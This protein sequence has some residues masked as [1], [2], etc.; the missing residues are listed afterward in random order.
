VAG[1]GD[2]EG[3]ADHAFHEAAAFE[4]EAVIAE[5]FAVV[6]GEDDDGVFAL[7]GVVEEVEEVTEFFV[8]ELDGGVVG[9]LDFLIL[10][11]VGML[12]FGLE[13]DAGV[14]EFLLVLEVAIL[15]VR[16]GEGVGVVAAVVVP[17]SV[18][19]WVGI[20]RIYAEEPGLVGVAVSTDE[21]F[22]FEGAPVGLVEVGWDV[23][24]AF[25]GFVESAEALD[26]GSVAVGVGA[27]AFHYFGRFAALPAHPIGVVVA[28][29]KGTFVGMAV[30]EVGVA[31]VDARF[32]AAAGA[33]EV[34]FAD[35]AAFVTGVGETAGKESLGEFGGIEVAAVAVDVDGARVL[36]GEEAGA[37][38]GADGG[39]AEGMGEGGGFYHEGVE[40]GG[41]DVGIVEGA[42]GVEA[43]LVG[44]VPE[45]VGSCGH[46]FSVVGGCVAARLAECGRMI[47]WEGS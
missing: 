39:L 7:A 20:E 35:E 28:G 17:G 33:G 16:A 29:V 11:G 44:A 45:D 13:I 14:D 36:P 43:L 23:V 1:P 34:E 5:G 26:F 4:D 9:G 10:P 21:F 38:G 32:L 18:E 27:E 2:H 41:V 15:K 46:W 6:A 31:I 30:L 24:V 37:A 3:D 47:D 8:E 12:G 22:G 42:D 25:G 40:A 19:G